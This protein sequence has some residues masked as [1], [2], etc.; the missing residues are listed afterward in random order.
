M[1]D[2]GELPMVPRD[3]RYVCLSFLVNKDGDTSRTTGVRCGGSFETYEQACAQA[4]KIQE[5]DDRHHVFVGET[6]KWLPYN[7]DP[8]SD[9]FK[10]VEYANEQLNSLMK[11]HKDNMEKA[12]LF[13]EM[14]KTD[15]MMD[16]L[17]ENLEERNKSRE[18]LVKKL[19]KAK[20][21]EEAKTLTK[22]LETLEEQIK[23]MEGRLNDC[24]TNREQLQKDLVNMGGN[25]NEVPKD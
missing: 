16:N 11:G 6:G 2:L 12:R 8:N 17:N 13:H 14:R 20:N 23:Q 7:P 9:T 25:P 3:Q 1:T 22:G 24:K 21:M 10:D 5:Y 19:S 15:K 4:K 18:E